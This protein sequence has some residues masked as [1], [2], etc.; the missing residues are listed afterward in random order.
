[1]SPEVLACHHRQLTCDYS[2]EGK[3][4]YRTGITSYAFIPLAAISPKGALDLSNGVAEKIDNLKKDGKLPPGLA[5]QLDIQLENLR[6][7][8][9]PDV[10]IIAAPCHMV[11]PSECVVRT[12]M[13]LSDECDQPLPNPARVI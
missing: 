12:V 1:M 11:A 8:T 9:L 3:G 2:A 10:E 5:E 4:L 7:D 6:N 13:G